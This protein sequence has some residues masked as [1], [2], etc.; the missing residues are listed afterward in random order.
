M[1]PVPTELDRNQHRLRSHK[2]SILSYCLLAG[3][4]ISY[5]ATRGLIR[6]EAV[7]DASKL[8]LAA[9]TA[10]LLGLAFWR[11]ERE[12][13]A[14]NDELEQRIRMEAAV[15]T[16]PISAALLLFIG[17][18]EHGGITLIRPASYWIALF[19]TY[20]VVLAYTRRRYR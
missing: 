2:L 13:L 9:V 5:G 18:L 16:L 17:T 7:S 6:Q 10:I 8:A 4:A 12:L 15:L 1:K 3:G 20:L 11:T 14:S 19:Y